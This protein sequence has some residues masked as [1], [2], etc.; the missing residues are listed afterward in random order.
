MATPNGFT[1]ADYLLARLKELGVK[2]VFQVPGDYVTNFMN[3][4]EQDPEIDAVGEVNEMS[5]AYAA[6]GYARYTGIGAVSLQYGVGTFSALNAIAGSYVER[7]PVVV[8]SA[9]PNK[10]N[11]DLIWSRDILFHHSTGDLEVGRKV[12]ENVTVACELLGNCCAAPALIDKALTAAITERRPIYLEAWQ[13]VWGEPCQPP[14]GRL[15]AIPARFDKGSLKAAIET[16]VQRLRAAKKQPIIMLGIEIAR[17][18]L[19][20]QALHLIEASG[21]PFTTSLEA[22]TVLDEKHPQFIGTYAG[23]ASLPQT[24]AL[25]ND[26]ECIL[27]LGVIFTDDY[28]P[29]LVDDQKFDKIT[30]VTSQ[31]TRTG[32]QY[33]HPR[34]PLPNY[35]EGLT[36]ALRLDKHF[37]QPRVPREPLPALLQGTQDGSEPLSYTRLFNSLDQFAREHH[38]WENGSLILGESS[39]LYVASN[40]MDMP[41]DSFVADAIW[42]SLGHETG[43]A[44]GVALGS[45]RRPFVVAG[46]GGFMMMCQSL[47][48][49]VRNQVNA[50]VFVV[51]NEVYAIEQAFVDIHAF[52][53]D[54]KFAPFDILPTW[55]YLALAKGFGAEGYQV[56][57]QAELDEL[58]PKLNDSRK[59]TLVQ[60]IIPQKDLAPQ[61]KALAS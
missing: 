52:D 6:D 50:V 5:A 18:G 4:L 49:L 16:T 11:R 23:D 12:F 39:S 36:Q 2:K 41:R 26:A 42:G 58:L 30:L 56:S 8:I 55:D 1:V 47:S 46:D 19:Q 33:Y 48:T 15:S 43:C 24:Q 32:L 38:W 35:M 25:M 10:K 61:I 20:Q 28:L 27:A 17:L 3:A 53:E 13:N 60:V 14:V 29:L 37:P 59:T 51:S 31:L 21:L 45:G 57:T 7:N 40:L 34:V 54:G 22:K 9:S 44:L